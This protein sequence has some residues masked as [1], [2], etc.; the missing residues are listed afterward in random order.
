[1]ND[2]GKSDSLEV[3]AKPPN[4]DGLGR[5]GS[6]GEPQT[7][8]KGE[9]PDTAK[10]EPKATSE[11]RTPTAEGVEGRG[12]A[13][14]GAAD[15]AANLMRWKSSVVNCPYGRLAGPMHAKVTTR[16]LLGRKCHSC[17][18]ASATAVGATWVAQPTWGPE[19][20]GMIAVAKAAPALKSLSRYKRVANPSLWGEGR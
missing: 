2:H 18:V 10:G 5:S 13:K 3:P 16:V 4:K 7:G 9:T 8:T 15:K 14:G 17:H 19:H 1:M 12:L 6:H 20:K 11:I